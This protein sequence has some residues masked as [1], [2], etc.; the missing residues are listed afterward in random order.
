MLMNT[1]C[2]CG[3]VK[4]CEQYLERVLANMEKISAVFDEYVIILCYDDSRDNTLKILTNYVE[5]NS[6]F[7]L[8]I[9][10]IH[11]EGGRTHK[12]ANAR[13]HCLKHIREYF[14][15]YKYF[16]MMDCDDVCAT[17]V[18]LDI[19]K[20][21]MKR[22]DW[23]G[24]SFN[25][26]RPYYDLWALSMKHLV[27]SCWHFS[28]PNAHQIYKDAI[29]HLFRTCPPG[30]LISVYSAFNGFGIYRTNKFIDSFYD[31]HSRLDLI[32]PFL[33]EENK[34]ACGEITPY[35]WGGPDQDSEHR[36]FHLHAI[37][38]NEAIV[39]ISPEILF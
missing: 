16:I 34:R 8:L 32:P 10:T 12:I 13:N 18:N 9:N 11:V 3:A 26:S 20:K 25:S 19:L 23:D 21:N 28:Q 22:T 1:C 39:A 33:M 35:Y 15:D 37:F 30:E 36:S 5:Q 14:S 29:Q 31:G 24:L 38:N 2:I 27:Y 4:D 6:R 7:H 17:P